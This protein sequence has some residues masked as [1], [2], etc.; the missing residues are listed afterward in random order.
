MTKREHLKDIYAAVKRGESIVA[1]G[2]GSGMTAKAAAEGGADMLMTYNT[3]VYRIQG[4]PTALAFLPYDDCNELAFSIAP[5]VLGAV[6]NKPI[7]IGLGAHDPRRNMKALIKKAEEM[8][9]AGV[10]NEPFI[11]IYSGDVRRQMEAAG[12]GFCKEVELIKATYDADMMS[13]AYVFTPEEAVRMVEAGADFIVAMVGGVTSGGSARGAETVGLDEAVET[14]NAIVGTVEKMGCQAPVLIHGGP[15]NDVD[16]V[17]KVLNETGALGYVTG[18]T[19][20]RIPTEIAVRQ[21]IS[22]FKSL[23][24]EVR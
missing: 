24:K 8:G 15:L 1:A 13:L 3:A 23:R 11:G 5:Q 12:L 9:I 20:E 7:L 18:S 17:A 16:A 6:K 21:K 10:S 14:V 22:D 19:G 4:V 2:V